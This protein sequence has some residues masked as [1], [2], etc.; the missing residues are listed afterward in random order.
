M[1]NYKDYIG[2]T[3]KGFK[4]EDKKHSGLSYN[5]DMDK[6][7]GKD[8]KIINYYE[9]KN[10]F[11]TDSKYHYPADLV[12]EQLKNQEP[13]IETFK[14]KR[15]DKVFVWDNEEENAIERIFITQVEGAKFPYICVSKNSEEVFING[16]IFS[17]CEW[18]NIKP[19]Q[20]PKDTLVWVKNCENNVWQQRFYSHFE[21]GKHYCFLYQRK[22]N[23]TKETAGWN[24]VT[25]KNPFQ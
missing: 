2:K 7:I 9:F 8:L 5:Y 10:C 1:K 20:I 21:N 3:F 18:K 4:F 16:G 22:S 17:I 19:I 12:I 23:E 24:I 13:Q 14:P 11:D 25:T 15:G 6:F